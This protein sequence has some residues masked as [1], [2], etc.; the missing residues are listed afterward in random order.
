MNDWLG[1]PAFAKIN[2]GL[3]LL[4]RRPDGY[5][6]IATLYQTVRLADRLRLRLRRSPEIRLCVR[7]DGVPADRGNLVWRAVALA[8]RRFG[9]QQGVEVELEK[10]IPVS[11]GL[12][13]GSSDAA[14]A[15]VG[16]LRL[17][18]RK[19]ELSELVRLGARLGADVPFFFL[20]GRALGVGRGDEVHALD[21]LPQTYCVLVCPE[22]SMATRSAYSWAVGLTPRRRAAILGGFSSPLRPLGGLGNDFEAIVFPRFPELARIKRTLAATGAQV[23]A[24][25]G[26]GSTVFGLFSQHAAAARVARRPVARARVFLTET[27]AR[28]A[29]ARALGLWGVVQ[30]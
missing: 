22:R 12:G 23:A 1:L 11:R 7:G 5:S 8:R 26:S 16:L 24:L 13:G 28:S 14:A 25:S 6:E 17:A 27:L 2:L 9:I 4:G 10:N 3:E 21:D 19:A 18:G 30:R 20:G 15:L 29:Y